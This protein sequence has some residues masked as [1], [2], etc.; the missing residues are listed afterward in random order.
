MTETYRLITT[1]LRADAT[2]TIEVAEAPLPRPAA[3]EVLIKVEAAPVH[4]S[5]IGA[6]FG[7]ADL[8]NAQYSAGKIVGKVPEAM[9]KTAASVLDLARPVGNECAGLV[10]DAGSDPA[11][12]ALIGKRVAAFTWK[13]YAQYTVTEAAGCIVL[14]DGLSSEQGAAAFVNPLTALGFVETMR[15][16]GAKALVHT[17]AASALGQM[18]VRICQE[19]GIGLVNIV[20]SPGQVAL[21]KDLGAEHVL[22]STAPGFAEALQAAIDATGATMGFDAIGGGTLNAQILTAMEVAANKASGWSLY[23]STVRKRIYIY[24]AL[25]FG[26]TVLQRSF[27]MLWD[28]GGWLL[29]PFLAEVGPEVADRLRARVAAE[30]TTTFATTYSARGSLEDMLAQETVAAFT[31]RKTGEKFLLLPNG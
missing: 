6:T 8:P 12:Q 24:G 31:A 13:S 19:D 15:R 30:L 1:T 7:A 16:G 5:D 14:P 23:G 25:D 27:G 29:M 4:P 20:R 26:P 2:L 3:N 28:V 21:L 10:V 22:D 17:A 11:A 18:L 9:V